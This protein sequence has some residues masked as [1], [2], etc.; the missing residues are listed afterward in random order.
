MTTFW[1][2]QLRVYF[3]VRTEYFRASLVTE[4]FLTYR[5]DSSRETPSIAASRGVIRIQLTGL[6][7]SYLASESA[8]AYN[9]NL[10]LTGSGTEKNLKTGLVLIE[11]DFVDQR[12]KFES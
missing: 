1:H 7:S 9:R 3:D 4:H 11:I 6:V 8:G 10:S 5:K 2:R 12:W